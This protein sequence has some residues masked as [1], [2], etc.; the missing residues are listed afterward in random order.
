MFIGIFGRLREMKL[1]KRDRLT[2][3]DVTE[4]CTAA[5]LAWDIRRFTWRGCKFVAK[6][7]LLVRTVDGEPVAHRWGWD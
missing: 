3:K 1:F 6:R 7:T 4:L 2:P 5:R